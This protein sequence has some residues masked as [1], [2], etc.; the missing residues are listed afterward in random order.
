MKLQIKMIFLFLLVLYPYENVLEGFLVAI[1][2]ATSPIIRAEQSKSMWNP[3]E[4]SP[5]L[6]VQT[7][8]TNSTTVNAVDFQ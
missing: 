5:R 3:S 8:Y 2:E 1:T 4:I 7:P 6:L